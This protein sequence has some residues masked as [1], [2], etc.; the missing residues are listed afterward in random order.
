MSD[1]TTDLSA[2]LDAALDQFDADEE[3]QQQQQNTAI[4][5]TTTTPTPTT[6]T[7]ALSSLSVSSVTASA[8]VSVPSSSPLPPSSSPAG[9]GAGGGL[10]TAAADVLNDPNS[11]AAFQAFLQAMA[12]PMTEGGATPPPPGSELSAMQR[13]MQLM[14]QQMADMA[15][16]NETNNNN[17]TN[18]A[19][20]DNQ[21]ATANPSAPASASSDPIADAIRMIGDG[22]RSMPAGGP[23]GAGVDDANMEAMLQ[24]LMAEMGGAGGLDGVGSDASM[25]AMVEKMMGSMLSK[26]YLY[27]PMKDIAEKYPAYIREHQATLSETDLDNYRKQQSCFERIVHTFDTEPNSSM[28]IMDLMNEMQQYGTPPKELV[29]DFMPPGFDP[30]Q[31]MPPGMAGLAG[32]TGGADAAPSAADLEAMKKMSDEACKMQ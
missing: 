29:G 31:T 15:K 19:I 4:Q 6:I 32:L 20:T 2:I 11:I 23:S 30:A 1:S 10:P 22:A 17:A 5:H 3:Q 27:Q 24:K 16:P 9:T 8:S 12:T 28:K 14:L 26:E 18:A 25:D 7:S 13:E 21:T